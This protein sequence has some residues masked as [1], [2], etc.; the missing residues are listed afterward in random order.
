MG[1]FSSSK[2]K[3]EKSAPSKP[4]LEER[5]PQPPPARSDMIKTPTH[6]LSILKESFVVKATINGKGSLIIGGEYEGDITI[7]DT[8]FVEK[9]ATFTGTVH[10]KNVKISGEFTGT[11][12]ATVVEVTKSGKLSGLINSN[13]TSLGGVINGIVRSIDSIEITDSGV[14]ETKECKS[15]QIK[16]E[17]KVKGCV[18]ASTLLEV[19]SAGSIEGEIITKGIRT[20]QGGSIIGNIQ[21]YD[22]LRHSE[23]K[24]SSDID[25]EIAKLINIKP[26]DM[27]KY[28]KKDNQQ[29]KRIP[30]DKK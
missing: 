4:K 7:D 5:S 28:A 18:I 21:T 11:L 9:G 19:T 27:Q 6:N 20:E 3:E 24:E 12:Y 17:G 15:K 13:K 2:K 25:P 1:F 30:A 29:I 23:G 26:D 16:V 8:L 14:I 10:A 22:E